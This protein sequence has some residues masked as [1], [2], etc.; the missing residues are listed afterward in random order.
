MLFHV[1]ITALHLP[2]EW[3]APGVLRGIPMSQCMHATVSTL[4]V[5]STHVSPLVQH[6]VQH[7]V[8]WLESGELQRH[9]LKGLKK[10]S[11][12]TVKMSNDQ[13]RP[14]DRDGKYV[15]VRVS[16]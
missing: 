16:P 13:E 6:L 11:A 15:Y 2:V 9:T 12:S 4:F 14:I 10:S 3:P 8:E 5:S 7:G 1:V